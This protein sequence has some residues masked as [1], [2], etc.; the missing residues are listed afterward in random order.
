MNWL[1]FI[2]RFALA[3]R[4]FPKGIGVGLTL[5]SKRS[6]INKRKLANLRT[7]EIPE[8]YLEEIMELIRKEWYRKKRLDK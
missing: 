5:K 7:W 4:G 2:E 6:I 8:P 3:Q 1:E